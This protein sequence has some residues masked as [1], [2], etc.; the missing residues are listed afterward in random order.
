[1]GGSL[2]SDILGIPSEFSRDP[3]GK[4]IRTPYG[5]DIVGDEEQRKRFA[6]NPLLAP[7][8]AEVQ[9]VESAMIQPD[10]L[11]GSGLLKA[12]MIPL[13]KAPFIGFAKEA[14]ESLF[15]L[16]RSEFDPKGARKAV[17][18]ARERLLFFSPEE[19]TA[20]SFG[21]G[22]FPNQ[23]VNYDI[24]S[25][26]KN[27]F[28]YED[29]VHLKRLQK[30]AEDLGDDGIAFVKYKIPRIKTGNWN[31]I[32]Q[33]ESL[34]LIQKAGFEGVSV[35]E[36]GVKNIGFFTDKNPIIPNPSLGNI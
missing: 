15:K 23:Q 19:S 17:L 16:F 5:Q 8:P 35:F 12:A 27:I 20:R 33:D 22:Q 7:D 14:P 10:D 4:L 6:S 26:L 24:N 30:A 31:A 25:K 36:K 1:V 28:D 3:F 34:D 18:T 29:P 13:K 2:Y 21:K 11:L 9:A 32:E